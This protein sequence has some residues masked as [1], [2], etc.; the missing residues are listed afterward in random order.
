[1]SEQEKLLPCPFCGSSDIDPEGVASFKEEHRFNDSKFGWDNYEP[2]MIEHRPCCNK[3]G[4]T[5][6]GDWNI[7]KTTSNENKELGIAPCRCGGGAVKEVVEPHKHELAKWMPDYEGG[8]FVSCGKCSA[9][10]SSVEDWNAIMTSRPQP[11]IEGDVVERVAT[12][13]RGA[14]SRECPIDC[15][16]SQPCDFCQSADLCAKA[17]IAAMQPAIDKVVA[18]ERARV[19][20]CIEHLGAKYDHPSPDCLDLI[21]AIEQGG[22]DA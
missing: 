15:S 10:T 7:R 12:L 3:C 6:D 20:R 22:G 18:E 14:D 2:H 19:K 1:M 16:N 11:A 13:I 9:M 17:A 5:T 21:K 8:V 4:A